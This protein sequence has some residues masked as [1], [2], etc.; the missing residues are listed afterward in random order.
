[1]PAPPA[2]QT[3]PRPYHHGN[4]RRTLVAEGLALL[5]E[6]GQ[7]G[8]SLRA[9][10]ARAGVSHAAPKNHFGQLRGLLTAIAAEGF[11][12]HVAYMRAGMKPRQ[13]RRARLQAALQGY[14]R[15]AQDQPH[16]FGLM[17]SSAQCDLTDP[18]LGAAAAESY[19]VLRE[20]AQDL[21]WDKAGRADGTLRSEMMLWSFVHGYATLALAGL[22]QEDGQTGAPCL[23]VLDVLPDFRYRDA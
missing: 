19:G 6:V 21:D 4:L 7:D 22:F 13:G 12:R 14:V 9:I 23:G 10:A 18:E 17:F 20:I 1:M 8:L 3:P 15:F 2:P 11:R 5:E 16:L